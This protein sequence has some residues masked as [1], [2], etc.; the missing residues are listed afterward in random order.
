MAIPTTTPIDINGTT[1]NMPLS[2]ASPNWAPAIIQL[3]QL[4]AEALAI[5]V[6]PYD[7]PPQTYNMVS[8]I[9]S[10][11][12]IPNMEFPPAAVS[13]GVIFYSVSRTASPAASSDQSGI[14]MFNYDPATLTW[15]LNNEWVGPGAGITFTI[16]PDGQVSYSTTSL[17]GYVSGYISFRGLAVLNNI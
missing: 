11:V 10:N 4:I 2:G 17:S 14:L 5:N 7:I 13:G 6:T 12:A 15:Q 8:N 9:N 16:A 3:F 1:V